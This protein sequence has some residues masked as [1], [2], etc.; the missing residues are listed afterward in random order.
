MLVEVT[1]TPTPI[2]FLPADEVEDIVQNVRT[3]I[4][5][6]KGTAPLYR[7]FGISAENLDLP[8]NLAKTKIA[9]E[10]AAEIAQ[11]ESRCKLKSVDIGGN[12]AG[13][14]LEI[15]ATIEI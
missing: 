1:N 12:F 4:S 5:T 3:I 14:D 11:F 6:V 2:N 13:G 8:M 7:E 15:I 10:L 9:A